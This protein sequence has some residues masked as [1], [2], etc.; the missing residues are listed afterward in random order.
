ML[1]F[2]KAK[3]H[4]LEMFFVSVYIGIKVKSCHARWLFKKYDYKK[5]LESMEDNIFSAQK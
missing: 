1:Q 5:L 2:S 3:S 4:A